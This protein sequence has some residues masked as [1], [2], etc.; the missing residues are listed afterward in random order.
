MTEN[1]ETTPSG[2]GEAAKSENSADCR[3]DVNE[4]KATPNGPETAPLNLSNGGTD[5]SNIA[6]SPVGA[7]SSEQQ[8]LNLSTHEESESQSISTK[9]ENGE[10]AEQK[11]SGDENA[12]EKPIS[13][14]ITHEIL[15]EESS[16]NGDAQKRQISTD[17]TLMIDENP[18]TIF[19][20][21]TI[22]VASSAVSSQTRAGRRAGPKSGPKSAPVDNLANS[23]SKRVR[24]PKSYDMDDIGAPIIPEELKVK[25]PKVK[26]P[27]F[28]GATREILFD[29]GDYCTVRSDLHGENFYL[30]LLLQNVYENSKSLIPVRWLEIE[31]TP[32]QYKWSYQ[33]KIDKG[34]ILTN[35]NVDSLGKDRV[36]LP[37]TEIMRSI[38]VL[39]K[40][41]QSEKGEKVSL[42]LPPQP[43]KTEPSGGTINN[44]HEIQ[45]PAPEVKPNSA[46]KRLRPPSFTSTESDYNSENSDDYVPKSRSRGAGKTPVKETGPVNRRG[47]KPKA[48]AV[49]T[50]PPISRQNSGASI[51]KATSLKI[52]NDDD[53]Q[54]S[55]RKPKTRTSDGVLSPIASGAESDRTISPI[56]SPSRVSRE[57]YASK[58]KVTSSDLF[59]DKTYSFD[60][61]SQTF[62]AKSLIRAV[63][64]KN[65]ESI[66][67]CLGDPKLDCV[68]CARSAHCL[69]GPF[70][71]AAMN[72]DVK[73]L[74]ML[75]D[76][77][78]DNSK[79]V[80]KTRCLM[81]QKDHLLTE[82]VDSRAR[83]FPYQSFFDTLL[84]TSAAEITDFLVSKKYGKFLE[85]S[86]ACGIQSG[87][88]DNIL[89]ILKTSSWKSEFDSKLILALTAS[90]NDETKVSELIES[91][92]NFTDL[93]PKMKCGLVH[94]AA[95]NSDSLFLKKM[96]EK[97]PNVIH[98]QDV[99]GWYPLHY[100]AASKTCACLTVLCSHF[101]PTVSVNTY[102][103]QDSG[104]FPLM[105][106]ASLNRV[107]NIRVL[108]DINSTVERRKLLEM[109][110]NDGKTALHFAAENGC[111]ESLQLLL[112]YSIAFNQ[113]Y[114]SSMTPLMLAA[115]KG[116]FECCELLINKKCD[117]NFKDAL[118]GRTA[119]TYAVMN[120]YQN[121]MSLLI[122]N[123]ANP[124]VLDNWGNSLV[125]YASSYGWTHCLTMLI[126]IGMSLSS[127][128]NYSNFS[129]M[130]CAVMKGH[131]GIA[132][133]LM[134]A[135]EVDVNSKDQDSNS[136]RSV[137][138]HA[139][140]S[141]ACI[142]AIKDAVNFLVKQQKASCKTVDAAGNTPMHLLALRECSNEEEKVVSVEIAKTLIDNGAD[143][144]IS[145]SV[146]EAPFSLALKAGNFPLAKYLSENTRAFYTAIENDCGMNILHLLLRNTCYKH[147]EELLSC[148][149]S[150]LLSSG[151]SDIPNS[152][153]NERKTPLNILLSCVLDNAKDP[154]K[155]QTGLKTLKSFFTKFPKAC[156]SSV[157]VG[158]SLEPLH[159]AIK[160][161]AQM[162]DDEA[163]KE[164]VSIL[165]DH[166]ANPNELFQGF[167]ALHAAIIEDCSLSVI[168]LISSKMDNLN[169]CVEHEPNGSLQFVD[170]TPL[171]LSFIKERI[172]LVQLF[173]TKGVTLNVTVKHLKKSVL[174]V[175]VET[176][177]CVDG[178]LCLEKLISKLSNPNLLDANGNSALHYA[179]KLK[180]SLAVDACKI[181]L[182]AGC[183]SHLQNNEAKTA[184][185]CL[186][187]MDQEQ[188]EKQEHLISFDPLELLLLFLENS[189]SSFAP[190]D[191]KGRTVMHYIAARGASLCAQVIKDLDITHP[192]DKYGN[193]VLCHAL[194]NR[195]ED[196]AIG[197]LN[198]DLKIDLTKL[199]AYL[200]VK[201]DEGENVLSEDGTL[202]LRQVGAFSLIA[203][204]SM[205]RLF[206]LAVKRFASSATNSYFLSQIIRSGQM[207]PA[208]IFLNNMHLDSLILSDKNHNQFHD[209]AL[210]DFPLTNTYETKKLV[211]YLYEKSVR[212]LSADKPNSV[213]CFHY[214]AFS[215]NIELLKALCQISDSEKVAFAKDELS[216]TVLAAALMS[217]DLSTVLYCLD[218]LSNPKFNDIIIRFGPPRNPITPIYQSYNASENIVPATLL[219]YS[220]VQIGDCSI[221]RALL[222]NDKAFDVNKADEQKMTPMM[223]AVRTGNLEKVICLLDPQATVAMK[224][225]VQNVTQIDFSPVDK[226]GNSVSHF[227]VLASLINGIESAE[228]VDVLFRLG[229]SFNQLKNS[230]LKTALDL[231]CESSLNKLAC[232]I[233]RLCNNFDCSEMKQP[234]LPLLLQHNMDDPSGGRPVVNFE[235][236][237][238][239]AW[240]K[241]KQELKYERSEFQSE[242][243]QNCVAVV[244]NKA[245]VVVEEGVPMDARLI[246]AEI[247]EVPVPD[248]TVSFCFYKMQLLHAR[249]KNGYYLHINSGP[250]GQQLPCQVQ[251][252]LVQSLE[253][254]K[255]EFSRLFKTKTDN[256]WEAHREGKFVLKSRKY[257]V[258][259]LDY[260]RKLKKVEIPASL[261]PYE[262]TLSK[263]TPENVKSLSPKITKLLQNLFS[264]KKLNF[265][266][267]SNFDPCFK[268][269]EFVLGSTSEELIERLESELNSL[270]ELVNE[271]DLEMSSGSPNWNKVFTSSHQMST[272]SNEIYY[273]L[274]INFDPCHNQ[275]FYSFRGLKVLAYIIAALK[276]F[277]S[278]TQIWFAVLANASGTHPILHLHQLL[279]CKLV[280]IASDDVILQAL[281][282]LMSTQNTKKIISVY[283]ICSSGDYDTQ[284]GVC[285]TDESRN[286]LDKTVMSNFCNHV[287]LWHHIQPQCLLPILFNG[288]QLV[289]AQECFNFNRK[290]VHFSDNIHNALDNAISVGNMQ[291][292]LLCHVNL[293]KCYTQLSA[294]MSPMDYVLPSN[295]DSVHCQLPDPSHFVTTEKTLPGGVRFRNSICKKQ[296]NQQNILENQQNTPASS[297][298]AV[299]SLNRIKIGYIVEFSSVASSGN[300]G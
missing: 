279:P 151:N 163:G 116:K 104:R 282:N 148:M 204:F 225:T 28:Q 119:L 66:K 101:G 130:V 82:D 219:I 71:V 60:D 59:Y 36:L 46:K 131:F 257:T 77:S 76:K 290:V 88:V 95:L 121:V 293:G 133:K 276:S 174:H 140:A 229:V 64:F 233:K 112:S 243:D 51:S 41:I 57:N 54:P 158:A 287:L 196:C 25:A 47:R 94:C 8:I 186:F 150:K 175:S 79:K 297:E 200:P 266:T 11:P 120:G 134:Y 81:G 107:E 211:K 260:S 296:P 283:G 142:W 217:G 53:Y 184:L 191:N 6:K 127:P 19:N 84:K 193:S 231:A 269:C 295:V 37:N 129:P 132:M 125:H 108:L 43:Q 298:Y 92:E 35:V 170:Y 70:E 173:L 105:V 83:K 73:T 49:V 252:Q 183:L 236:L 255:K 205:W 172:D 179:V 222:E 216:R 286:H 20:P 18:S 261:A 177:T 78:A 201:D 33:D 268:N 24:Y 10:I 21:I 138:H 212:P 23:R 97:N 247:G 250:V 42:E 17:G 159:Q 199:I 29:K 181:L 13:N 99:N 289:D 248:R 187:A 52:D 72:N 265:K 63:S 241:Y 275:P 117:V 270:H 244:G 96:I 214:A 7:T 113:K 264:V 58:V 272:L 14:Q 75:C 176:I 178:I 239:S 85:D 5:L 69:T 34:C 166:K 137:L 100:A 273:S 277:H 147:T 197:I 15:K 218:N 61:T 292:L 56:K 136:N 80:E 152:C 224:D 111:L 256:T 157:K 123:G 40:S 98:L 65:Q 232:H 103:T 258:L 74:E 267:R 182:K 139:V 249:N 146:I 16:S 291:Y 38:Y 238:R 162:E 39:K 87:N 208:S 3:T 118:T 90:A 145:Y 155:V 106:A 246:R 48:V 144:N 251:S 124:T 44:R 195:R 45:K 206:F 55:E 135:K 62:K 50:A 91:V 67:S 300:I 210:A 89:H 143:C 153:D 180:L 167:N 207:G 274:P 245:E 230:A 254:A 26:K 202:V 240:S 12:S 194:I 235:A 203:H 102:C 122:S 168:E 213:L 171:M 27:T 190:L 93:H 209:M 192:P 189:S 215:G 188:L 234:V 262:E 263:A 220:I 284:N 198:S 4:D 156:V 226:G 299:F 259:R 30:C 86:L 169:A 114:Q 2:A 22:D 141:N 161:A 128:L 221:L 32:N 149:T 253:Q 294:K 228:I 126:D 115:S 242:V 285:S 288:L 68:A 164:V 281:K 237:S 31:K 1:S 160:I 271:I 9:S 185:H 278:Y 223:Y 154:L 227:V 165:L 109:R 110:N 280:E